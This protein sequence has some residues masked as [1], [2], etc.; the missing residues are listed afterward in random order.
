[1][2]LLQS[3]AVDAR[4]TELYFENESFPRPSQCRL[5]F[6]VFLLCRIALEMLPVRSLR[7]RDSS[8]QV[9]RAQE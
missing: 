7:Q 1:M 5:L 4:S 6:G 3:I 9:L 8:D 2:T